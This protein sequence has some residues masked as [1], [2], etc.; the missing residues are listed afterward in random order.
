MPAQTYWELLRLLRGKLY[1]GIPLDFRLGIPPPSALVQETLLILLFFKENKPVYLVNLIPT[2]NSNYNTRDADK[3]TL[4]HT[5]HNFFKSYFFASTVIEWNKLDPNLRSAASLSVFKKNLLKFIRPSRNSVFN[6]HN[7]KE[8]K[9]LTRLNLGPSHLREHKFKHS[10]Q[11]TL[12]P[13]CLCGLDVETN[14]HFF[15]LLPLVY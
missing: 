5:K 14:T 3:I 11:D 13:F 10:F 12:N 1:H 8:I 6:C 15:S 9:Y 4:F 2:K 7:C